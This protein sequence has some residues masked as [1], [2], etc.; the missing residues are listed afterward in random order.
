MSDQEN[1]TEGMMTA[2]PYS[3]GMWGVEDSREKTPMETSNWERVVELVHTAFVEGRLTEENTWQAVVLIL[4]GGKD[5]R[6][7]GL[8]EVMRKVV[9]AILN[10]RLTA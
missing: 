5:Y 1:P 2:G 4:K 8:V 3:T 7:I 10:R 9:E 6:G